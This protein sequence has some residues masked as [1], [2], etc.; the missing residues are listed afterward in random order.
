M[1]ISQILGWT[2]TILF[3]LMLIP[4][5]M[6][7]IRMKDTT[8][9][10]LSL[11]IVYLIANIIAFIYAFLIEEDPLLIKYLIAVITAV[12]YICIY[13]NFRKKKGEK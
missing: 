6:K 2:A 9:V 8:G 7:T 13:I 11:F 10:S 4:Q 1:D 3:S 5:M 12:I